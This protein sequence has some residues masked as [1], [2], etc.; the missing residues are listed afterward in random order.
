MTAVSVLT[1]REQTT[2]EPAPLLACIREAKS[3]DQRAFENL[4]IATERRVAALSWRILGDAEEVK[5]A[6]QETFLRVFRHLKRY[7]EAGDFHAWL[8]RITINVCRDLDRRRK[9]RSF[10]PLDDASPATTEERIDDAV[11]ARADLALVG[12]ALNALPERERLAIILRDVEGFSTE[13]VAAILGN[14]RTTVRV[15]IRN[16]RAKIRSWVESWRKR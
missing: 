1:R 5:D 11:A 3:G 16:A 4:M 8:A 15:Q 14:A 7:D 9:R 12:R 6:V 2:A 13:E 10:V